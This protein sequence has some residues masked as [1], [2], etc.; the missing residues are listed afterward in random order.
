M[1]KPAIPPIGSIPQELAAIL[2]PIK[3]NLDIITGR[4]GGEI[5]LLSSSATTAQIIVK[6]N[7]VISRLNAST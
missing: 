2:G 3:A 7:E 6:L 4:T 1:K 5:K